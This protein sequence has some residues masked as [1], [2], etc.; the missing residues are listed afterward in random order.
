MEKR[1]IKTEC[2]YQTRAL[3]APKVDAWYNQK[4]ALMREKRIRLAEDADFVGSEEYHNI[5]DKISEATEESNKWGKVYNYLGELLQE[6]E[7]EEYYR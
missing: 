5:V 7:E 2:I 6:I 4:T 1:T 3:I